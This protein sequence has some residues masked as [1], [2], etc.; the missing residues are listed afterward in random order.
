MISFTLTFARRLAALA[1]G[2]AWALPAA[3]QPPLK[4]CLAEDEMPYSNRK[5]E[6]FEN[7]LAD[8]VGKTLNRDVEPVFWKDPRYYVRDYL[9][10]G[11]CDVTLGVD[12]GDPRLATTIPYYRSGYAF[13]SRA[14]SGPQVTDWNSPALKT[15][16]R[17]A[18]V[19]GTPVEVMLRKIG[20]YTDLFNYSQE[21]VD[22]KSKRNQYVKY[23]NAKLVGEVVSG[24]AEV[25]AM[26]APAAARY[27]QAASVPLVMTLIPDDGA[28][29]DGQKVPQHYSTAMG[30]RKEDRQLLEQLNRV[31][32]ERGEAIAA[33]LKEEGIPLI[34]P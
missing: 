1:L 23:D 14:Q 18:F 30:V 6:G 32:R 16:R 22:F 33:L 25:A 15:V 27:V 29:P 21:L 8:L 10:K 9:E 12:E 13:I 17:I 5:G 24:R 7:R 3:G 2:V 26:W 19:P 11:L 34:K 4:V 28:R 20:R 31:I